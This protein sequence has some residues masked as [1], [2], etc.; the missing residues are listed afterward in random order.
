[1]HQTNIN[2]SRS[3]NGTRKNGAQMVAINEPD[4]CENGEIVNDRGPFGG[5]NLVALDAYDLEAIRLLKHLDAILDEPASRRDLPHVASAYDMFIDVV[6]ENLD[7]HD[8]RWPR[9]LRRIA[10]ANAEFAAST[11]TCESWWQDN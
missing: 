8:G 3:L 11:A 10:V 4:T 6:L 1:M 2:V 9:R 5:S 7:W